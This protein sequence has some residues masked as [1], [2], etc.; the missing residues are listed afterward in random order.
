M[1]TKCEAPVVRLK[2]VI[3]NAGPPKFLFLPLP[4]ARKLRRPRFSFFTSI[5]FVKEQRC[6]RKTKDDAREDCSLCGKSAKI[7]ASLIKTI[8]DLYRS[9]LAEHRSEEDRLR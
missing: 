7:R 2:D 4:E 5:H 1:A 8:K 6:L 9:L 3:R